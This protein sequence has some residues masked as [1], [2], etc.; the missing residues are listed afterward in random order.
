[1]FIYLRRMKYILITSRRKEISIYLT[2]NTNLPT[3]M[4][5]IIYCA[6]RLNRPSFQKHYSTFEYINLSRPFEVKANIKILM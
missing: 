1:M 5:Y 6:S 2:I 4:K 3:R